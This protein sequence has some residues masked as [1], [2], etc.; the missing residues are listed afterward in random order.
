VSA[1]VPPS[2]LEAE[3][4]VLGGILLENA[5]ADVELTAEDFYSDA[6]RRIWE[7]MQALVKVGQPIDTVTLGEA[8][9]RYGKLQSVGGPEYLLELTGTIP[10]VANIEAHAKIVRK[11]AV[12]RRMILACHEAAARLYGGS[13]D[14]DDALNE[15][16][17]QLLTACEK[18]DD[19]ATFSTFEQALT[20]TFENITS[21]AESRTM[22]RGIPTGITRLDR[23]TAGFQS[24]KLIIVAGRPG[25]GKTALAQCVTLAAARHATAKGPVLVYSLEMPEDEVAERAL[26]TESGVDG[27]KLNLAAF[28]SREEWPKL[29]DAANRLSS[30]DVRITDADLS[31]QAVMRMAQRVKAREGALRMVVIDYLQLMKCVGKFESREREVS[32]MSRLLKMFAKKIGAPVV[33]LCQLNRG[34]ENRGKNARPMLS[35]LRESGQIEANADM[36]IFVHREEMYNATPENKG[37]AEIIVAKHRGGPTGTVTAKWEAECTRFRDL[38]EQPTHAPSGHWSES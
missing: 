13:G 19:D 26:S 25:A 5:G 29:S 17:L 3:R 15:A 36:V 32:E 4:A 1:R 23:M 27:R 10:T 22:L 35:D 20:K 7:T 2:S 11:L 6:H 16:E 30:L 8:L 18:R 9:T 28:I 38:A 14:I 33:A 24:G 37:V 31:V 34:V 12:A 21:R